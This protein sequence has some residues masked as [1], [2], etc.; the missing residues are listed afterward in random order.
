MKSTEGVRCTKSAEIVKR[1]EIHGNCTAL[2]NQQKL[3]VIMK[4]KQ[5]FLRKNFYFQELRGIRF[6]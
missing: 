2:S 4:S 5:I 3:Q 6:K 1:Y